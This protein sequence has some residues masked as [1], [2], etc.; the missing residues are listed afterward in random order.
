MV[1]AGEKKAH[2]APSLLSIPH[3]L[4]HTH[5]IPL[6]IP[7]CFWVCGTS[8]WSRE[9]EDI[10]RA[11]RDQT[12]GANRCGQEVYCGPEPHLSAGNCLRTVATARLLLHHS[13]P[14][15]TFL[16]SLHCRESKETRAM[17]HWNLHSDSWNRT[18]TLPHSS[19]TV[20]KSFSTA[21]LTRANEPL[22]QFSLL[23]HT[24]T[25]AHTHM[26]TSLQSYI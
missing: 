19:T 22:P 1:C 15:L 17:S 7:L 3:S 6:F 12:K 9:G 11:G 14:T 20:V 18:Q 21:K 8:A 26:H 16:P 4:I 2:P 25:H 13:T 5:T 10:G 24:H 23:I